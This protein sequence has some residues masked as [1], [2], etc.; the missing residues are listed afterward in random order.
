VA[1]RS[2]PGQRSHHAKSPGR[3]PGPP[4]QRS[5][6]RPQ[7]CAPTATM[8]LRT[9]SRRSKAPPSAYM[10]ASAMAPAERRKGKPGRRRAARRRIHDDAVHDA[11]ESP[12]Y[13]FVLACTSV[14]P[15]GLDVSCVV[16]R[17]T[18]SR[19]KHLHE[20]V[21]L[22]RVAF[23]Y[24]RWEFG[25]WFGARLTVRFEPGAERSYSHLATP[26]RDRDL[27]RA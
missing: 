8:P 10:F 16:P 17:P 20:S 12:S 24:R 22:A 25:T 6:R 18:V 5:P 4:Q 7:A 11:F 26:E 21:A 3:S 9:A 2:P 23:T 27:E 14:G 1:R 13:R 19:A 15:E